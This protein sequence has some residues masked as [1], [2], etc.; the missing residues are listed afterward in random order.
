MPRVCVCVCVCVRV[1]VC[2]K[3]YSLAF[4]LISLA[5][6]NIT[7]RTRLVRGGFGILNAGWKLRAG[8]MTQTQWDVKIRQ[9]VLHRI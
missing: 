6:R 1:C 4:F 2:V 8:S 9:K 3:W 5:M 7:I